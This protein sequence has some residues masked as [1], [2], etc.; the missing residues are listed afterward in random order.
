LAFVDD[1]VEVGV[2]LL[3]G[4]GDFGADVDGAECAECAGRDGGF[5]DVAFGYGRLR[6]SDRAAP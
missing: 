6:I 4:A 1:R 3:D 5:G 2:Q